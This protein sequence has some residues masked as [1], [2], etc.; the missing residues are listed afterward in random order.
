MRGGGGDLERTALCPMS[1]VNDW[2][3]SKSSVSLDSLSMVCGGRY[4]VVAHSQ[5]GRS[6][7]NAYKRL[8][9]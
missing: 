3:Q 6:A 9:D 7:L 8:T 2:K 5:G 1:Y 4:L